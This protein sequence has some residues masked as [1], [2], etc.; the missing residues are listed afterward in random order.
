MH[1]DIAS[2]VRASTI[3]AQTTEMDEM[4]METAIETDMLI[5]AMTCV[6]ALAIVTCDL[7]SVSQEEMAAR[8][9]EFISDDEVSSVALKALVC[10]MTN[11]NTIQ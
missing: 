7:L 1:I 9:A 8:L 2:N 6:A 10:I 3:E 5:A 4:K 11:I